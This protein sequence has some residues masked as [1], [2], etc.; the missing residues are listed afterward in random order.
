MPVDVSEASSTVRLKSFSML[1]NAHTPA[2]R[3]RPTSSRPA[4][5]A[6]TAAITTNK[7]INPPFIEKTRFFVVVRGVCLF[8]PFHCHLLTQPLLL[9][10][11]LLLLPR[12]LAGCLLCAVRRRHGVLH[13]S[14]FRPAR[15]W[16]R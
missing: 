7:L 5:S 15:G 10:V 8:V 3:A 4:I 12:P 6:P 16:L 14:G 13:A 11:L 2:R 1:Q 9:L